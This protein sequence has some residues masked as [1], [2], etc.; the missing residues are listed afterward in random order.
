M[1][2]K[3][4][5]NPSDNPIDTDNLIKQFQY[6][7]SLLEHWLDVFGLEYTLNLLK[8]LK[9]PYDSIWV[10]VN[11]SRIDFDSLRE[12]FEEME[13]E[14]EKHPYLEDFLIVKT[15]KK[16]FIIEDEEIPAVIVDIE[17]TTQI[18]LG[19]DVNTA[20]ITGNDNFN[21]GDKIKIIN[22]AGSI[23][24][25]GLAQV[26]SSEIP[27]LP[28]MVVVKTSD[29]W[30][31]LPPL[32]ESRVYRRGFFNILTPVQAL[33]VKSLYLDQRDNILVV[34]SDKGEVASYIAEETEHKC[35]ITVVGTNELQIKA[36][37]RQIKR[38]KTKAIRAVHSSISSFLNELHEMKY[39]SVYFETQNSRTA[40]KPVF[41]SN[42]TLR[43][44]NQMSRKQMK[45]TGLLY[46]CL[47]SNA[48]V[49]YVTHSINYLENE[50]VF[51]DILG[52]TYYESQSFPEDIRILQKKK[53]LSTRN[54]IPEEYKNKLLEL[55]S[56]T[57]Y[58]DPI[59]TNNIGGFIGKFKFKKKDS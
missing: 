11:S 32:T 27:K 57:L 9:Q 16:D 55:K 33:G 18:A 8:S 46:R 14:V 51:N 31:Y 19:K 26:A 36:I 21:P 49:S 53:I 30:G 58:L 43:R 35:P 5:M 15:E 48:S 52:K 44:M 28:Q 20:A 25:L 4:K 56:S 50:V 45:E 17:S 24:A 22:H 40:V 10:Q 23:I 54:R 2:S 42:L 1:K 37:N 34:S 38:M 29:S 6:K 59:E 12:I 47:H 41:S 13:M 39:S 3:Y 7:S